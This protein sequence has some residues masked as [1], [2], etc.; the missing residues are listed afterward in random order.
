MA[1][2]TTSAAGVFTDGTKW[3]GGVAPVTAADTLTINHAM[4]WAPAAGSSFQI[5]TGS[6]AALT[7]GSAGSL[8]ITGLG[9]FTLTLAG[10]T[11]GGNV[12]T[13]EFVVNATNGAVTINIDATGAGAGFAM[14]VGNTYDGGTGSPTWNRGGW[15]LNGNATY[16]ITVASLPS[17]GTKRSHFTG[18]SN[19][20][21]GHVDADYVAFI[22]IGGASQAAFAPSMDVR[23]NT[24]TW[25]NVTLNDCGQITLSGNGSYTATISHTDVVSTN[26]ATNGS[27]TWPLSYS[28]SA[29]GTR[30][31]T[32]C[33]WDKKI[34]IITPLGLNAASCYFHNGWEGT[35]GTYHGGTLT[36]SFVRQTFDSLITAFNVTNSVLYWDNPAGSNP[37]WIATNVSAAA[38]TAFLLNDNVVYYNGTDPAGNIYTVAQSNDAD[39]TV[40]NNLV[41]PNA[42]G[43]N[44]GAL[45]TSS[46]AVGA[47]SAIT[48]NHN[49]VF[50]KGQHVLEIGHLQVSVESPQRWVSF[51]SNLCIGGTTG[52]KCLNVDNTTLQDIIAPANANYNGSYQIKTTSGVAG[53]TNEGRGYAAKWS[54]TP[55]A[56]DVDGVD[57]AFVNGSASFA[58]WSASIG[59]AG[60]DEAARAAIQANPALA[61][62]LMAYLAAAYRPTAAAYNGA[63]HDGGTIG[64][65]DWVAVSSDP[66]G[67]T[68]KWFPGLGRRSR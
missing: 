58:T 18:G 63:A 8:T 65:F 21:W 36:N 56:N 12:S 29:A 38:G 39:V 48:V 9:A 23:N 32:R 54:T 37:H 26:T 45:V 6:G 50:C 64:A 27:T 2:K 20:G 47:G 10:S 66:Y 17:D 42:A 35:T 53:F 24:H 16:G 11:A 40:N 57:P 55:G 4:T 5:G 22:R 33:V 61:A 49:T 51:K 46:G 52:Y 41:L 19:G 25:S 30:T 7:F 14:L 59:G 68:K 44:S 67:A 60:T 62:D 15:D 43:S 34:K 3:G 13:R 31:F 1:A 28:M